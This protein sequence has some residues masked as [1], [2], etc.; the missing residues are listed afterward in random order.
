MR[1]KKV[2]ANDLYDTPNRLMPVGYLARVRCV[3]GNIF[4][5]DGVDYCPLCDMGIV[6]TSQREFGYKPIAVYWMDDGDEPINSETIKPPTILG[7]TMITAVELE[8]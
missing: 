5:T 3:C 1:F 7:W 6:V 4:E 8:K 2:S